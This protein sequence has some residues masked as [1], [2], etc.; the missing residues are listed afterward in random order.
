MGRPLF[1]GSSGISGEGRSRQEEG[2]AHAKVGGHRDTRRARGEWPRKTRN[3]RTPTQ[4]PR[5]FSPSPPHLFGGRGATQ[6]PGRGCGGPC[7]LCFP[8]LSPGVGGKGRESSLQSLAPKFPEEPKILVSPSRS[9]RAR[10]G[11]LCDSQPVLPRYVRKEGGTTR[12]TAARRTSK[13]RSGS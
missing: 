2:P 1:Y 7:F 4:P 5:L 3:A 10:T 11:R 12:R 9:P 6:L 8:W 13:S